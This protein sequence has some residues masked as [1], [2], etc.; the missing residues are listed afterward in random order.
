MLGAVGHLE[1]LAVCSQVGR[2][3]W[4]KVRVCF[5]CSWGFIHFVT[6]LPTLFSKKTSR[7]LACKTICLGMFHDIRMKN[8]GANIVRLTE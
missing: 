5:L 6:I 3:A 1:D 8:G 4:R 2:T 7:M